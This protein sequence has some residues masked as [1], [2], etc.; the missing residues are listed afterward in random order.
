MLDKPNELLAT[1]LIVNNFINVGIV[2]VSAYL[3]SIALTF[4]D[5]SNLEFIFQVVIITTIWY[6]LEKLLKVYANNNAKYFS[7]LMSRPLM[8]L[9]KIF[10]PLIY[11]LVT[12]TTFIDRRLIL[13]NQEVSVE[14][15]TKALDITEHE[16]QEDERRM[17]RSIVEFGN[18][19][20]KE[21][22]CSRVD[23]LAI[24]QDTKFKEVLNIIIRSGFSR[25][26][27]FKEQFDHVVGILYI[28]DLIPHL[29]ETDDFH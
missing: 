25:I 12:T 8:L 17:L 20:V 1:I 21:V 2:V 4:P 11:V 24:E 23:V 27:V 15:I 3:T 9:K 13:R 10:S 14:D 22:M 28:K 19:D 18:T 5:N 6:C 29:H 16:S 26:P 7:K